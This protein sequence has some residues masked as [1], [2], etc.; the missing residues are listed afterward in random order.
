MKFVLNRNLIPPV[1][2]AF[3]LMAGS[4][5]SGQWTQQTM[6]LR[7]GWNAVFLEVHPEPENC[8]AQF[9]GLPVES[10][11]DWNRT[12]ESAQFVQDPS[13]LLPGA[14]GWLTWF[15]PNHALAGVGNLFTL[16]DGRPYLIK[17]ANNAAP[18]TWTVTGRPSL[19]R[20]TW[21]PGEV[22]FVGFHVGMQAPAFQSLFAGESALAGQ[23][24]YAL[25]AAGAW[26]AFSDL[27]TAKPKAGEAY[28]VRCRLPAKAAGTILVDSGS[29]QG[30][31]FAGNAAEQSIRIRNA[32]VGAR[33]ISVRVLPSTS[34]PVGQPPL[35]G[36][37][38]LEYWRANY[39]TTNFG[40]EPLSAP[41]TFTALP[42]GQEWNIRLGVRRAAA[43]SAAPGSKYQ[44]LLEVTDDVGTRWLVPINADPGDAS[45]AADSG[46]GESQ[47]A[48]IWIGEA[49]LKAV[50]QPAHP[51][52]PSLARPAGS[53]FSF[54]IIMHVDGAGTARLLRHVFLVRKPPVMVS[55]PMD[56]NLN[57]IAEPA[58]TVAVTDEALIPDIIGTGEIV[59]RRVSSAAFGFEQ[60]VVL[61]GGAFGAGTLNATL[62]LD[63]DHPLNPFKHIFHPDHNN[64]DERFEQKL[65]E[66]KEAF[67]VAR[68][69]SLQFTATD[70]LGLNPPSWGDTE[71][72]GNY[73]ETITGL[74]R[75]AIQVS[76]NFRL[77]RVAPTAALNQ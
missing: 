56:P 62:T 60:P 24:V 36:P 2:A 64:L 52:D 69:L 63:Y 75:S 8:D 21:R 71:L 48:G 41:L 29:R 35:A 27:S 50:S 74:H 9:S 47:Y 26:R 34:P 19:R 61:T 12:T 53:D 44:S 30:L 13:T 57:R 46:P 4:Q 40:W 17:V 25:D 66:G 10:V 67:T 32:S 58:R 43:S 16:R 68:S 37:V 5:A 31:S 3:L 14:P 45:P 7:P 15:P 73:R 11:W 65:P 28:L 39:A 55:D 54:R 49:V 42:A 23:P 18:V 38:P 1:L 22:N 59:G 20:V 33:N 51:S 77:V 72:G 6:Q 70:P 76:G